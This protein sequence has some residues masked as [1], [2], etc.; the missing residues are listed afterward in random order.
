MESPGPSGAGSYVRR[1][2]RRE[3]APEIRSEVQDAASS[4]DARS[5]N[6]Y[7]ETPEGSFAA[8]CESDRQRQQRDRGDI[9]RCLSANK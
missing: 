2:D 3:K 1:E 6:I 7:G 9:P 4:A 8:R 5:P